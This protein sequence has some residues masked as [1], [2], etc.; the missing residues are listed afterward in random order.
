MLVKLFVP[1]Q[2]DVMSVKSV[3]LANSSK[4]ELLVTLSFP[5][6]SVMSVTSTVLTN[7]LS[8]HL[9]LLKLSVPVMQAI[10]SFV[11][12]LVSLFLILLVIVSQLNLL[13][14]LLMWT[15]NVLIIDLLIIRTVANMILQNHLVLWIFLWCPYIFMNYIILLL[16]IFHH[17]FCN[18]NVDKAMSGVTT[19]Y[20]YVFNIQQYCYFYFQYTGKNPAQ[21]ILINLVSLF[22]NIRFL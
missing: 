10:R 18:N 4:H 15:R 21:Y 17:N 13:I 11:I 14:N 6:M 2:L 19:F 16:F 22:A 7:L 8:K 3:V 20:K 5:I 9:M 1:V 12:P